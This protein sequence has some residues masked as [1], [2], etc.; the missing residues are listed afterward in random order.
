MGLGGIGIGIGRGLGGEEKRM[1]KIDKTKYFRWSVDR[2]V[3]GR[4]NSNPN[5]N[6]NTI[7]IPSHPNPNN[8]NSP[9]IMNKVDKKR[10]GN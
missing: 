4:S 7:P 8:P 9:I 2:F 6:P 5:P 10:L 3:R 1:G